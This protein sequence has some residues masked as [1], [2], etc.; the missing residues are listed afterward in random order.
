[1]YQFKS[2][3]ENLSFMCTIAEDLSGLVTALIQYVI[4]I[5]S[6]VH[7]EVKNKTKVSIKRYQFECI[8]LYHTYMCGGCSYMCIFAIGENSVVLRYG[9]T[10]APND[11]TLEVG[12]NVISIV[13]M[14]RFNRWVEP[15]M[16]VCPLSMTPFGP[17]GESKGRL[18]YVQVTVEGLY[19]WYL[20]AYYGFHWS[21][22]LG[23][24][25]RDIEEIYPRLCLNFKNR[26]NMD[27]SLLMNPLCFK[28]GILLI[29]GLIGWVISCFH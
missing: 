6:E 16:V 4:D 11:K 21:H 18:H 23:K 12:G 1:M 14:I 9:H 26:V 28:D 29:K 24:S 2:K 3:L 8:F 15:S 22:T 13:I 10:T 25:L 5:S 7:V 27:T 20:E 19:V 17:F